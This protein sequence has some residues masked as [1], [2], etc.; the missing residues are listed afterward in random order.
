VVWVRN[1]AWKQSTDSV[2]HDY[3]AKIVDT[4][5]VTDA[6]T[7]VDEIKAGTEDLQQDTSFPPQLIASYLHNP[8]FKIWGQSDTDPYIVFNLQSP[9]ANH[10]MS[11]QLVREAIE[12]AINK[13]AIAKIYGGTTLNPI[14]NGAVAPGNV[15]YTNYN[16][17]PTANNEGNATKCKQLLKQAGYPNG[18]TIRDVYRNAGDHPAVFTS[19]QAD[20]K[21]CGIT[22]VGVPMEQGPYYAFVEDGPNSAKANQWDISEVGWVPDW[23]G[24]NGRA[25]IVPLFQTDCGDPTTNDGCIHNTTIDNDINK[26]L[27]APN[28]ATAAPYWDATGQEVM[29]NAYIVPLTTQDV[30]LFA[31]K[32]VQHLIYNPLAEQFNVT[33]LWL[34][35]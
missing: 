30:V 11:K 15:G 26:A 2:R 20:L 3:V 29:K 13:V 16:Y 14:L 1:P 9:D 23:L 6:T 7:Q 32:S 25:N 31:G 21:A 8:D 33:Q 17:Y 22:S 35:S 10:A 12:Y 4:I 18:F 5:G 34:S 27:Q 24:A 28:S 19:V